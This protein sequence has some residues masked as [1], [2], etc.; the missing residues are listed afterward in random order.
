MQSVALSLRDTTLILKIENEI[1]RFWKRV[2]KSR[3]VDVLYFP[4]WQTL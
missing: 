3:D 2:E 1:G 4:V